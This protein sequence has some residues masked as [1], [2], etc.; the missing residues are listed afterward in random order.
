MYDCNLCS[1]N[2]RC[3]YELKGSNADNT[4]ILF[5]LNQPDERIVDKDYFRLLIETRTGKKLIELLEYC[6]R[7]LDDVNITNA[8][9]GIV[10]KLDYHRGGE[11]SRYPTKQESD[12]CL[13]QVL[14]PQIKQFQPK[15]IISFGAITYKTLF[16]EKSKTKSLEES[17]GE[18]N[19]FLDIPT[20]IFYHPSAFWHNGLEKRQTYYA[21]AKVFLNSFD[22]PSGLSLF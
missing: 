17:F 12:V 10:P 22:K 5:I 21:V 3:F 14:L 11:H 16:P 20:L 8:F 9:K 4:K 2:M 19:L 15:A 6:D 1:K 13:E 7:T 18:V